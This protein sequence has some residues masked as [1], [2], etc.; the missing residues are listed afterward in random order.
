MDEENAVLP[1]SFLTHVFYAVDYLVL[2]AVLPL[3][4][5]TINASC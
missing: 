1:L 4:F 5:L 3:S 2:M